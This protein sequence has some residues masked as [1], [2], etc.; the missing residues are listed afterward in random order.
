MITM[1]LKISIVHFQHQIH[2]KTKHRY[3]FQG[4]SDLWVMEIHNILVLSMNPHESLAKTN[5]DIKCDTDNH[6]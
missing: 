5:M 1:T 2:P 6:F 4:Y 3:G